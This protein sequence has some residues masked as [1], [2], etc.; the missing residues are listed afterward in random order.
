MG[1][2]IKNSEGEA[3]S[4]HALDKEAAEFWGKEAH[5]KWYASPA[6]KREGESDNAFMSRQMS[7]NWFDQLG[8]TIHRQGNY[9]EKNT[10]RNVIHSMLDISDYLMKETKKDEPIELGTITFIDQSEEEK[11]TMTVE[12][13]NRLAIGIYVKLEYAKPYVDLAN[14]WLSKGYTPHAVAD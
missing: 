13:N 8:Y 2:Q 5:D 12:L 7:A 4:I 11:M 1:F 3:I 14:H 10:W 9:Y 6:T